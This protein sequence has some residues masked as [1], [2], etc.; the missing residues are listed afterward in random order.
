MILLPLPPECWDYKHVPSCLPEISF[1]IMK[2]SSNF[3]K[4]KM[5]KFDNIKTLNFLMTKTKSYGTT[6]V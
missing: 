2:Q 4:E 3:A 1:L 6:S 5:N